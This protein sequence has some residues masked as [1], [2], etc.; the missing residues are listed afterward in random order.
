MSPDRH[1]VPKCDV[2]DWIGIK[3]AKN[4]KSR[5][6]RNRK[7]R[8]SIMHNKKTCHLDEER[9]QEWRKEKTI[10]HVFEQRKAE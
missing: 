2:N 5:E 9:K 3:Y 1:D 6:V 8:A 4:N 7:Y 10:V